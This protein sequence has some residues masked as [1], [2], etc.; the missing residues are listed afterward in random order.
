MKKVIKPA[1]IAILLLTAAVCLGQVE[2]QEPVE[3]GWPVETT[4]EL[5]SAQWWTAQRWSPYVVGVGI[6]LLA[7]FTFLISNQAIGVSTAYVRTLGMVEK[8]AKV[9]VE[10]KPYYQKF[11]PKVDWEW[12]FVLGLL[13]GA[14]LS[15]VTSGDFEWLWVPARW[16]N[17]F[18]D[19]ILVR[20]VTA[21]VG[22]AILAIG[23]RWAGGCTSGHGISGTLQLVLSS[24]IAVICFFI[25]G[26]AVAF[27]L[28][29]LPG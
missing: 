15:A 25:G 9:P 4:P 17:A 7:W 10:Q 12:M 29:Y 24:W 1:A 16:A 5:F 2:G 11:K 3:K 28:F 6:G 27:I 18:G 13:I 23:A 26:I 8:K 19:N 20:L 21:F 14:F 22:G